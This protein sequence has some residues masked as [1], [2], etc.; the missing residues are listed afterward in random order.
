MK[1]KKQPAKTVKKKPIKKAV[2]VKEPEPILEPVKEPEPEPEPEPIQQKAM[3][4]KPPIDLATF[5][6]DYKEPMTVTPQAATD[7]KKPVE[8]VNSNISKPLENI[9][10]HNLGNDIQPTQQATD[11]KYY[12]TGKKAG[13]PRPV[14][15]VNGLPPVQ[16]AQQPTQTVT[17][18]GQPV[19]N[20][21]IS[22]ALFLVVVDV[23]IPY[24]IV[25]INN[26]YS[27]IKMTAGLIQLS[28]EQKKDLEPIA[29][30]VVRYLNIRANPVLI[31]T[32][33]LG[34]M[35]AMN[36]NLQKTILQAKQT[37]K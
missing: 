29:E 3:D 18:A 21:L 25:F 9:I 23:A 19:Q 5:L 22:G 30:E 33:S 11:I 6:G 27:K 8:P 17:Q 2:K 35:Y 12:R 20:S 24:V 37:L 36:Y 7:N 13:Q 31:F 26:K 10:N 1:K 28:K 15:P 34:G 16:P 4:T 14:K 32:V